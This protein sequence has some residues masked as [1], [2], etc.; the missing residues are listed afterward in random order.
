MGG[1]VIRQGPGI[2]QGPMNSGGS[3]IHIGPGSGPG[4]IH[5]GS[6]MSK[7]NFWAV[8]PYSWAEMVPGLQLN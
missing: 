4:P 1:R 7:L 5:G 8:L 3:Y 2:G 6:L